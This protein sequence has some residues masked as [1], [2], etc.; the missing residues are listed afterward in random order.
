MAQAATTAEERRRQQAE[1]EQD[2]LAQE[3]E[4]ARQ[5]VSQADAREVLKG[6]GGLDDQTEDPNRITA[7]LMV[8]PHYRAATDVSGTPGVTFVNPTTGSQGRWYRTEFSH[9][10]GEFVDRMDVYSDAEAPDRVDFKDSTYNSG[11][12]IVNQEGDVVGAHTIMAVDGVHTASSAFPRTSSPPV[13]KNLV[14]RGMSKM[15]FEG[16]VED[17]FD[18]DRDGD[19]DSMDLNDD[20][21]E[22]AL[23]SADI[24]RQQLVQYNSGRF[25]DTDRYPFR[26]TYT[27]SGTLQ[28]AS[29]TYRCGGVAATADCKVQKSGDHFNFVGTWSFRPSSGTTDVLIADTEFMYFGWWSRQTVVGETWTFQTF[30]GPTDSR[31]AEVSDVSGTATYQGPAA[32]YYAIYQPLGAQS[33]QGDFSATA[34]LTANFD[35]NQLHGTIDQFSGHSDW[36]LTLQHAPINAGIASDN[37]DGVSWSIGGRATEGGEWEAAFYSNFADPDGIVP[38]GIA[39]TVRDRG[40]VLGRIPG[41]PRRR[42]RT[43]DR[44]L[45]GALQDRVLVARLS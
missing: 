38:S 20:G 13:S 5:Q 9:T 3:A 43:H 29:G 16:A 19:I 17:S 45:R 34:N 24:T 4:D 42:H 14:D 18:F 25:R 12:N 11:N 8:T 28:G 21:L 36:S 26:Y 37:T 39:G 44:G 10:G 27:T 32:G 1:A 22:A 33:G 7:T 2:R 40:H 23:V 6:L 35:T 31:D 15:Q 30:H 41:Y